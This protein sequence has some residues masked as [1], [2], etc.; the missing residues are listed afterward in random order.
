MRT[1]HTLP[2][3]AS[4]ARLATRLH[5]ATLATLSRRH[6]VAYVAYAFDSS[7][8]VAVPYAMLLD[9]ASVSGVALGLPTTLLQMR[10]F[11]SLQM[12][13][14][15]RMTTTTMPTMM[16]CSAVRCSRCAVRYTDLE[17]S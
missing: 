8:C 6:Y 15:M 7:T 2:G 4:A 13:T 12:R 1:R 5:T 11:R 17:E 3:Q 10:T 9:T 14:M 16:Q